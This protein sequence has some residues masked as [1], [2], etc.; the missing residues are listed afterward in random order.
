MGSQ[1]EQLKFDQIYPIDPTRT[2]QWGLITTSLGFQVFSTQ[3][4]SGDF[5]HN[6]PSIL[7]VRSLDFYHVTQFPEL[8]K[9][10]GFRSI[11]TE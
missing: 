3:H 11:Q 7:T 1:I 10:L 2:D 9:I 5:H 4:F 8:V 6:L